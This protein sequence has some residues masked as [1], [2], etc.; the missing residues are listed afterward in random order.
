MPVVIQ[1]IHSN[2]DSGEITNKYQQ[3]T[4]ISREQ[5]SSVSP[6]HLPALPLKDS[7]IYYSNQYSVAVI[8]NDRPNYRD[9]TEAEAN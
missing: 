1:W 2:L 6:A 3:Q 4:V 8:L 9:Q 5:Q 7:E